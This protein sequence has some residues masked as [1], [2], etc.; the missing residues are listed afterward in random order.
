MANWEPA[1]PNRRSKRGANVG[2]ARSAPL[3][4]G[5]SY[6]ARA[7]EGPTT[8]MHN[9][10]LALVACPARLPAAKHATVFVGGA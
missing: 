2:A 5:Q 8:P 4:L 9:P 1:R 6:G 10:A 7:D 3:A